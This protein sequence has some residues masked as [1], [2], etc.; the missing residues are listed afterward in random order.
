MIASARSLRGIAFV[1]FAPRAADIAGR[2]RHAPAFLQLVS[3][4]RSLRR[5]SQRPPN[6]ALEATSAPRFRFLGLFSFVSFL[7]R[8]SRAVGQPCLSLGR[9]E[10]CP[11]CA[12][13]SSRRFVRVVFRATDAQGLVRSSRCHHTAACGL[14]FCRSLC[15]CYTAPLLL[16]HSRHV[17]VYC[18]AIHGQSS[19]HRLVV[20]SSGPS[21][22]PQYHWRCLGSRPRAI[23]AR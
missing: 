12:L 23:C 2:L 16:A 19:I 5:E 17:V 8:R 14:V 18:I 1:E 15:S 11:R 9:S 6:H 4:S 22:I 3:S 13:R 10:T 20:Q 21:D 7:C